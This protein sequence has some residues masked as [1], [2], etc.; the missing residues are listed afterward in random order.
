MKSKFTIHFSILSALLA[1]SIFCSSAQ[2]EPEVFWD[3]QTKTWKQKAKPKEGSPEALIV[4]INK[5][6]EAEDYQYAIQ[7]CQELQYNFPESP[8]CE[9]AMFLQAQSYMNQGDYWEAYH[10]FEKQISTFPNGVFY[11]RAIDREYQIADAFLR[12]RK[13]RV[14]KFF[15][16]DASEDGLE[17]LEKI[18]ALV[19]G[20]DLGQNAQLRIADYYFDEQDYIEAIA[21]YDFFVENN[22]TAN[23]KSYAMLQAARASFL[24]YR[25]IQWEKSPLIDAAERYNVIA[26]AYPQLAK[27]ENI[28][29]ILQQIRVELAHKLW[30]TARFYDRTN[31]PKAAIFYYAK[32]LEKY[33]RS[34]WA[35]QAR[36]ILANRNEVAGVRQYNNPAEPETTQPDEDLIKRN[37]KDNNSSSPDKRIDKPGNPV[38]QGNDKNNQNLPDKSKPS[39]PDSDPK[40]KPKNPKKKNFNTLDDFLKKYNKNQK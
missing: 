10:Y 23:K 28:A 21:A 35:K 38:D 26:Q 7:L 24:R 8:A 20:T 16:I 9:E 3:P 40:S 33:P 6:I 5:S 25:G 39:Q 19:P 11:D 37:K 18:A 15:K 17:I 4:K 14:F 31:K 30:H 29:E 2:A 27:S 36:N 32:L 13:R 34:K 1:G 12:G 22:P